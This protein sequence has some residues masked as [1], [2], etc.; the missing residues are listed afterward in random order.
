MTVNQFNSSATQPTAPKP[1]LE[2]QV[3]RLTFSGVPRTG[4][5]YSVYLN[6]VEYAFTTT[7]LV[8]PFDNPAAIPP[9]FGAD[10]SPADIGDAIVNLI[11]ADNTSLVKDLFLNVPAVTAFGVGAINFNGLSYVGGGGDYHC[12]L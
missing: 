6:G 5:K 11:N 1:L 10:Q 4:E 3:E 12:K 9:V 2:A 7:D 8:A